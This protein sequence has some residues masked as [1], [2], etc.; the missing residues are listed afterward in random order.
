MWNKLFPGT[1][2]AQPIYGFG[3]AAAFSLWVLNFQSICP[4]IINIAVAAFTVEFIF[5][6]CSVSVMWE[7]FGIIVWVLFHISTL[8]F[9]PEINNLNESN[10]QEIVT[11][12]S[13]ASLFYLAQFYTSLCTHNHSHLCL[14]P[15]S[16]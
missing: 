7:Q 12:L 14:W 9:E 11:K 5:R 6:M 10:P 16:E 2:L 8:L 4:L 1:A 3:N 15:Y 13:N